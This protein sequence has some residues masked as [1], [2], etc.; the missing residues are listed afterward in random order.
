MTQEK[1]AELLGVDVTTVQ[2]W[3]SGRRPLSAISAGDF[4][5]I[6]GRLSRMGAPASTGRYLREA[7]EADQVLAL[8]RLDPSSPHLPLNLSTLY[9]LV[10]SRPSLLSSRRTTRASFGEVLDKLASSN[11]LART[12]RNQ[13][14]GLQYAVR[15]ADR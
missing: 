7:V 13:L 4:L 8:Q 12:E 2:G 1:F 6:C 10:A 9:A 5:R 14:A 3:E 15:I 11:A